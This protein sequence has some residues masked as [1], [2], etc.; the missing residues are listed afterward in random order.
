VGGIQRGPYRTYYENGQIER[1]GS[2]QGSQ[3]GLWTNYRP[4]GRKLE[5]GEFRHGKRH[6]RWKSWDDRGR[7]R[8][9]NYRDNVRVR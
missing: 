9:A 2:Y 3:E 8:Q 1:E 7:Q 6:G 4:D 5:E